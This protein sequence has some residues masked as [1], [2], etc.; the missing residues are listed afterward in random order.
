MLHVSP[1]SCS[2]YQTKDKLARLQLRYVE[3]KTVS[4]S[5]STLIRTHACHSNERLQPSGGQIKVIITMTHPSS[6][7]SSRCLITCIYL[8]MLATSLSLRKLLSVRNK[9]LHKNFHKT[10]IQRFYSFPSFVIVAKRMCHENF[11]NESQMLFL[12]TFFLLNVLN[13]L[14]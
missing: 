2:C 7:S 8:E 11:S 5:R 10:F 9:K 13:W 6:H 1:K 14:R 3:R 12:C 4:S